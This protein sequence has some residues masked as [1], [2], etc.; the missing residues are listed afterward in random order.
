MEYVD[1][2]RFAAEFDG[3]GDSWDESVARFLEQS[4][5]DQ[6]DQMEAELEQ[7]DGQLDQRDEIHTD[8]VEDLEWK[9]ERYTARLERLYQQRRGK[10]D[11]KRERLQDQI[12]RFE[13]RLSDEAREHWRDRQKLEQE[14]R[15][16]LRE[17]AELDDDLLSEFL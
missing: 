4:H 1:Y 2:D 15:D 5:S 9:V 13:K 12:E 3:W 17:L 7:I 6:Q 16:I 10:L 11:G 14:R 8:I